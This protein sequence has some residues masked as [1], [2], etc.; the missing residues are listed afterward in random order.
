MRHLH[1]L[2]A[3]VICGCSEPRAAA[4]DAASTPDTPLAQL[5]LGTAA[6]DGDGFS[7]LLGDQTLVAGPQGGFHVW[8]KLRVV[9]FPAGPATL[10]RSASAVATGASLLDIDSGIQV[11]AAADGSWE[12]PSP[13]PLFLCP[14]PAGV[15]I[16]DQMV[17]ADIALT[18]AGLDQLTAT[19]TF[20]A[21]CPDDAHTACIELC[22]G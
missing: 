18:S 5:T 6:V 8:L 1:A 12:Q 21:H 3:I 19:T 10:H 11:G 2:L 7:P 16:I 22:S 9:G 15:S 20:T 17:R 4:V 14:T 13:L